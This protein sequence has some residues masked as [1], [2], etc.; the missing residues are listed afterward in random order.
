VTRSVTKNRLRRPVGSQVGGGV[1]RRMGLIGTE[2]VS[3]DGVHRVE[4]QRSHLGPGSQVSECHPP[5]VGKIG[6][7][8][9]TVLPSSSQ[10]RDGERKPIV[11][12]PAL[13]Q[14]LGTLD[15]IFPVRTAA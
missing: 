10:V 1:S 2:L 14:L 12:R 9:G 6:A 7:D 4:T 8:G 11:A 5:V 13:S 15:L 3:R